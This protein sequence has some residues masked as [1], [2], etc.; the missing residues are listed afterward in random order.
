MANAYCPVCEDAISP[1]SALRQM[2]SICPEQCAFLDGVARGWGRAPVV[3][4][5]PTTD[6]SSGEQKDPGVGANRDDAL[7]SQ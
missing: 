1:R 6:L 4:I 7:P 2:E 3:Q 5:I